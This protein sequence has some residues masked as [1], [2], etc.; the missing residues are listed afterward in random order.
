MISLAI[1]WR[2]AAR[3][4]DQPWRSALAEHL[5]RAER[6]ADRAE[7]LEVGLAGEV[8]AVRLDRRRGRH[9]QRPQPDPVARPQRA[10]RRRAC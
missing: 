4:I 6:I 8:E 7:L 1:V 2:S 10:A 3:P 9:Q 5:R